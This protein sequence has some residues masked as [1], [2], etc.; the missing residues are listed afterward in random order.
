MEEEKKNLLLLR[1]STKKIIKNKNS[2]YYIKK[3]IYNFIYII[4]FER[5]KFS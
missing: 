5:K 4:I 1:I 2:I 3:I